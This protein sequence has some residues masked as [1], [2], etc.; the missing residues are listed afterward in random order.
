MCRTVRE[1][2]LTADR[3]TE[4]IIIQPDNQLVAGIW[5]FDEAANLLVVALK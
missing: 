3:E 1:T 5:F 2:G 4:D